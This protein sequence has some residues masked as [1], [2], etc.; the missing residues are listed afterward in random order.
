MSQFVDEC[1]LHVKGGDGGAGSV[2]FR[3]EAHVPFGGPDGGDGGTGGDV[4]L[5]VDRNV[6]SLIAFKDH[7]HRAGVSG[8][9]GK[10]QRRH[11]KGGD[12]L[13]VPVPEGTVVKDQDGV[14]L[15]DLLQPG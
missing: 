14:V 10:G 3:R 7:P 11:G 1:G 2:S 6:S 5:V 12:D 9:H 13:L 15:A 4:W 8:T